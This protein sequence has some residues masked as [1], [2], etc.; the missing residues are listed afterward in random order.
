MI[1]DKFNK[2][3]ILVHSI[4]YELIR[5]FKLAD[6]PSN[7]DTKFLIFIEHLLYFTK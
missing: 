3:C 2:E 4:Y 1:G 5:E 7:T 6:Y